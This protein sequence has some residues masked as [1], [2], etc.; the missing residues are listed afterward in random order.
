MPLM[1]QI[2][3]LKSM[4]LCVVIV[5]PQHAIAKMVCNRTKSI[6]HVTAGVL[7]VVLL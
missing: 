3:G 6:F 7:K 2:L 5:T 1:A 4:Q